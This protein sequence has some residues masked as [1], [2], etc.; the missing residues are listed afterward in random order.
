[1][2]SFFLLVFLGIWLLSCQAPIKEQIM[3]VHDE[4]MP[5]MDPLYETRKQLQERAQ[6]LDQSSA[7]YMAH[8]ETV[9]KIELAES[10]M[11]IWMRNYEPAFESQTDSI[12]QYYF[13]AQ[14]L[15]I[16]KVAKQ[17][18]TALDEGRSLLEE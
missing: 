6:G 13:E 4:V 2:R 15:A 9:R 14:K 17:M 18:T 3:E 16:E 10:E 5:L 8:L 12:T 7:E 1:M 11:M